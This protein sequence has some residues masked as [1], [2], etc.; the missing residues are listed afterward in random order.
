MSS[1]DIFFPPTVS[2][3]K[4]NSFSSFVMVV[5]VVL[6]M[7]WSHSS[8]NMQQ[9]KQQYKTAQI[10]VGGKKNKKMQFMHR[11]TEYNQFI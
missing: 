9:Y 3:I 8:L 10:E 1:H 4:F 6:D 11:Y 7:N 2:T 5:L